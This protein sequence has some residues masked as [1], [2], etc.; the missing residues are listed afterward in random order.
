MDT[1]WQTRLRDSQVLTNVLPVVALVAY[2][3]AVL[4][5]AV[6]GLVFTE[7]R[8]VV[9]PLLEVA[10]AVSVGAC[11]WAGTFGIVVW[12]RERERASRTD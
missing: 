12:I 8:D 1:S 7:I 6:F 2:S 10:L 4:G 9:H 5:T 11:F 3:L